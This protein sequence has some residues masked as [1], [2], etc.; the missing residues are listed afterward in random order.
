MTTCSHMPG[1]GRGLAANLSIE[2]TTRCNSACTHCFT[3]ADSAEDTRLGLDFVK[4][5]TREGYEEG[6]R[7]LHLTGGEPLLWRGLFDL[8]D[9]VFAQGFHSVFLNTNGLL[10][11][12]AMAVALARY[13][14]LAISVSLQ[15]PEPLHDRMRGTGSY[16]QVSRGISAALDAGL[17]LTIFAATGKTLLV[18][19]PAF[20]ATVNEK[21]HGIER[22]T[23]I[24]LIRVKDD[25]FDLTDELLAPED[26]IRL[27]RT[28]SALNL[29]GLKTDVLYDPLVNVA[30]NLLQLPMVPRSSP[31]CRPGKLMIRANR[32]VTFA[33]STRQHFGKYAPGMIG[34]VLASDGY[35]AAVAPDD[36]LCPTCR[37]EDQC[38]KAGMM[39]PSIGTRDMGSDVPYCQRVLNGITLPREPTEN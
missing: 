31:L 6:Y 19:L 1:G 8:L 38:R 12:D 18:Q 16:R 14:N 9:A 7:H 25:R 28:V 21:F 4:T 34:K 15:G 24:Q 13:P 23:L 37:F 32:D 27:V 20:A 35:R 39:R 2:L 17:A 5:I 30:A 22:L 36:T 10:M 26:Y 29:Y 3:R 11:T 33:H